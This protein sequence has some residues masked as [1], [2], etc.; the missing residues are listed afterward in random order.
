MFLLSAFII[1]SFPDKLINQ[2]VAS[3]IDKMGRQTLFSTMCQDRFRKHDKFLIL[4]SVVVNGDVS[5]VSR[6]I[7]SHPTP[8]PM[9][10]RNTPVQIPSETGTDYE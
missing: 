1:W 2:L 6:S 7:P 5:D 8:A 10:D 9:S 3:Q 4:V